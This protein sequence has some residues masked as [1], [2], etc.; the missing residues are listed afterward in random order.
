M[1][2][3][4]RE[5]LDRPEGVD[6][7][8]P[9]GAA[10]DTDGAWTVLLDSSPD[11]SFGQALILANRHNATSIDLLV[12]HDEAGVVTRRA[13]LFLPEPT[14]WSID[15]TSLTPAVAAERPRTPAPI[16]EPEIAAALDVPEVVVT[17]EHGV[18]TGECRGVEIARVTGLGAE[19]RIDVGVGAYDQGAF[20]V[21]NPDLSPDASLRSVLAQVLEHRTRGAEPHPINR[22]VRE[23]WLRTEVLD[24]PASVGVDSLAPIEGVALREGLY[25]ISPAF[26]LANGDER[27]VVA[28]SVGIDLDLVPAAAEVAAR[29][30]ADRIVLVLPERD[31]HAVTKSLADR[32]RLPVSFVTADEPW[33]Q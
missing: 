29:E 18:V 30:Q 16:L 27:V 28:F 17:I 22:L 26:A 1:R 20:A 25:E 2:A 9:W 10:I 5:R 31:Q 33:T 32:C 6:H 23:R 13:Q 19:Q 14:V 12:E 8:A 3:L 15:G 21:M 4:A 11:R 7:D 24:D